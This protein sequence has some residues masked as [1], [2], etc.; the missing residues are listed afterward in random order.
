MAQLVLGI[1]MSHSTM[2]TL[3]DTFWQEWAD[4]DRTITSLLDPEGRIIS[5]AQLAEEVGNRYAEQA[6]PQHWK[7]QY[8]EVRRAIERLSADVEEAELDALII[9]G[10]DQLELFSFENIP[11]LAIYYGSRLVTGI[12]TSRFH[13]YMRVGSPPPALS[14]ALWNAVA[15]GYAMDT[16]HELPGSPAFARELLEHLVVQGFDVTAMGQLS[17][18]DTTAGIGHAFGAFATQLMTKKPVPIVPVLVNTYFP[19][20][21]PKPPRCYDFG[22]A[23]RR[24]IEASPA[25]LRVGIAASGGLS[26]FVTDEKFDQQVLSA[27]REGSEEQLRAIPERHLQFGNSEIRNWIVVAAATKGLKPAWDTY[28]PIYRTAAGTGCGVTFACWK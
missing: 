4:E 14:P 25:H 22:L 19:P 8:G 3:P 9:I 16:H 18:T 24:A 6:T 12:M 21:Q 26:H 11:A 5:F 7:E 27:L 23:L 20:N 10:D 15:K 28:I 2:V 13:E 17:A 1:G